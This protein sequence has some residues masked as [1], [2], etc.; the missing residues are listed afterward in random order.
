MHSKVIYGSPGTGKTH[1]LVGLSDEAVSKYGS[2]SVYYVSFTK[3]AAL[4][5]TH[6]SNLKKSN[7]STIHSL[8]FNKMELSSAGVV[9]PKTL[10]DFG[11]ISGFKFRGTVNVEF[12]EL[13]LGDYYI[14]ML[15]RAEAMQI[16]PEEAFYTSQRVG[17][18]SDFE[19]FC[20][21][22]TRWKR[23]NGF[24]DFTDML[25]T[26]R[27][28]PVEFGCRCLI[29]DEAQDL[30]NL[31]W[32]VIES[33]IEANPVDLVI[34]AGDDDQAIFEW[35]GANPHGMQEFE[36]KYNSERVVLS[37]SHRIP[38]TVHD[39]AERL[40]KTT[41][42]R[43]DKIY[44][45]AGHKGSIQR[46]QLITKDSFKGDDVLVLCRNFITRKEMETE[47]INNA[48][49]FISPDPYKNP[50]ENSI[51]KGI[52]LLEILKNGDGLSSRELGQLKKVLTPRGRDIFDIGNLKG[53]VKL[54]WEG[55][56]NVPLE[57]IQ[58]Y[59]SVDLSKPPSVR[60]S[61]IHGAKGGEASK[62][63]LHTGLTQKTVDGM[64]TDKDAEIRVWYVGLTRVKHD[65]LIY[66]GDNGFD[67]G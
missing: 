17:S 53:L 54:G 66:E 21:T 3:T 57:H 2:N 50:F 48:V 61:T 28:N 33:I 30:S 20:N 36:S 22:Y 34:V 59:K 64:L 25:R 4:E 29:V 49:P 65:L 8:C 32:S 46:T 6:R 35:S 15:G 24:F 56:I 39:M 60:V 47:L 9:S 52:K 23:L 12:E 51:A 1:T 5:A 7:V 55:A 19:F 38:K 37:Q 63:V 27:D 41:S 11:Q 14:F 67:L 62:V 16:S 44:S 26:Y 31:Q 42:K 58:L 13:E 10:K 18:F 45:S 40:I 43:V